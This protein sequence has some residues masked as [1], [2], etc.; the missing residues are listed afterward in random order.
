MGPRTDDKP[1]NP[2]EKSDQVEGPPSLL[3]RAG[4]VQRP[5]IPGLS[6]KQQYHHD[7][8]FADRLVLQLPPLTRSKDRGKMS[9]GLR[10]IELGDVFFLLPADAQIVSQNVPTL[11]LPQAK[12]FMVRKD[13]KAA[14]DISASWALG[15]PSGSQRVPVD[16][17][18]IRICGLT[19]TPAT[20]GSVQIYSA[21][22]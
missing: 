3:Q 13:R 2:A 8:S 14:W 15:K 6:F 20:R 5:C 10:C 1:C 12:M 11:S 4:N 9:S 19:R 21:R 18:R 22:S 7:E 17:Y 16:I